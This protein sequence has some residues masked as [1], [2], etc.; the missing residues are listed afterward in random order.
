MNVLA[1]KIRVGRKFD[2]VVAGARKVFMR[3]GYEGASVDDIAREARVSKAT[4]YSY[5]PDKR[6]L[7]TEVAM[8]ECRRQADAAVAEIDRTL[9]PREVLRQAG[10]H[11]LRFFLSPYGA[12]VYRIGVAEAGR[13]PEFGRRFYETGPKVVEEI[14]TA[15]FAEAEARGQLRI[16]DPALAAHQFAELCKVDL[17]PRYLFGVQTIFSEAELDRVVDGAVEMFLARYG[18]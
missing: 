10:H 5:F 12:A 3:D 4:L 11:V 14:M 15:Y 2:Q 7:F 1:A 6:L 18:A 16:P 13:F 8:G 9:P 17:F